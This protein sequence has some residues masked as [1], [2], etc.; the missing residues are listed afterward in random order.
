MC[1]DMAGENVPPP[2]CGSE[3][4]HRAVGVLCAAN[5]GHVNADRRCLP[6][7]E[8][9]ASTCPSTTAMHHGHTRRSLFIVLRHD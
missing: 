3:E 6:L 5:G 7:V 4:L 2:G 8:V 1:R 9:I